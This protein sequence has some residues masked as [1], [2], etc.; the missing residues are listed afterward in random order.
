MQIVR[1][2]RYQSPEKNNVQ[3]GLKFMKLEQEEIANDQ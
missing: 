3:S 2:K 1:N